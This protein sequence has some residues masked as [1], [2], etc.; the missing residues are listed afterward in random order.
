MGGGHRLGAFSSR[1]AELFVVENK[2]S[3]Q[4]KLHSS[5]SFFSDFLVSNATLRAAIN[6]STREM[7]KGSNSLPEP[8]GTTNP[9]DRASSPISHLALHR[10]YTLQHTAYIVE[11]PRGFGYRLSSSL[12][13]VVETLEGSPDVVV[14]DPLLRQTGS[15][16]II[17][18][19]APPSIHVY[20]LKHALDLNKKTKHVKSNK[21]KTT[22]LQNPS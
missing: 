22:F 16:E 4:T 12:H 20:G 2:P 15:D 9:P 8:L 6:Y 13:A 1:T 17:N 10:R 19:D 7:K 14:V 18:A 11:H 21:T 3:A 5:L